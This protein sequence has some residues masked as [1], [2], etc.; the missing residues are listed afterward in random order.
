LVASGY[1]RKNV[2]FHFHREEHPPLPSGET[3]QSK[4]DAEGV[5]DL[6]LTPSPGL[7]ESIGSIAK[8]AIQFDSDNVTCTLPNERLNYLA[9]FRPL[10]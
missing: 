2:L 9:T 1:R 3:C 5:I 10:M 7:V 6:V 8:Q 4:A